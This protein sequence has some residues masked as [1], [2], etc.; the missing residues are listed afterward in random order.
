MTGGRHRAALG[1]DKMLH[2][3]NTVV[4]AQSLEFTKANV[5]L[6]ALGKQIV[7]YMK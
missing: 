2:G 3:S 4:A 5:E 6:R 7:W 1:S